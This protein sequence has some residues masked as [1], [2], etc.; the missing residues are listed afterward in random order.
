MLVTLQ[1]PVQ[2]L[3][4]TALLVLGTVVEAAQYKI[5]IKPY[6]EE[7]LASYCGLQPSTC[8]TGDGCSLLPFDEANPTK[9]FA[10][11]ETR[12]RYRVCDD[13]DY[14]PYERLA[15]LVRMTTILSSKVALML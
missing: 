11:E 3:A 12:C 1:G 2:G 4:A 5:D 9:T 14:F 6:G 13:F 15:V 10:V 8:F 7:A